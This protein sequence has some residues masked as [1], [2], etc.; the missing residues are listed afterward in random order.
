MN[1]VVAVAVAVIELD[2]GWYKDDP[3]SDSDPSSD[4]TRYFFTSPTYGVR[5][6]KFQARYCQLGYEN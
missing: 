5:L 2:S 4:K 3:S 6:L 1:D